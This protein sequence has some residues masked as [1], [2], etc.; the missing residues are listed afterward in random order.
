MLEQLEFRDKQEAKE[1]RVF[2][3]SLDYLDKRDF[4]VLLEAKEKLVLG[5]K[6]KRVFKVLQE[7]QGK[8]GNRVK[9]EF[10]ELG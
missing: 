5:L 4:L 10:K 9:Q 3:V 8:L 7:L 1:K 2:K 6:D